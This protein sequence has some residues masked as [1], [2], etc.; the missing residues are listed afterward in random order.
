MAS[1]WHGFVEC[2]WPAY[3]ILF[4]ALAS[5]ACALVAFV[6]AA[7]RFRHATAASALAL[8]LAIA[9]ASLG[10]GGTLYQRRYVEAIVAAESIDPS[11]RA[12][13]LEVGYAEAAQCTSVGLGLG[14]LPLALAAAALAL[15]LARR[16]R[17]G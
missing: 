1:V 3:V 15:A 11:Q 8:A 13:I 16:G 10:P 9:A 14:A 6:L 12:R 7:A 4:A 2:G 17:Q 5:A